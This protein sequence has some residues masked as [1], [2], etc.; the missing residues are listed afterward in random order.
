VSS[1]PEMDRNAALQLLEK[2]HDQGVVNLDASLREVL[3]AIGPREL[4]FLL[5]NLYENEHYCVI[6]SH[7]GS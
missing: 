6:V 3:R 2:L 4:A 7:D 5:N 1:L